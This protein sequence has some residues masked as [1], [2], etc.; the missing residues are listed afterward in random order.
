LNTLKIDRSFIG[1]MDAGGNDGAIVRSIVALAHSLRLAVVAEGV[2]T[3]SQLR[4]LKM[5]GADE[6]QGFLCAE[7]LAA[8]DFEAFV[9][10]Y[11]AQASASGALAAA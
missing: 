8:P 7:A 11:R 5:L 6:Y 9:R 3:E 4:Y 2:E 1:D 10:R